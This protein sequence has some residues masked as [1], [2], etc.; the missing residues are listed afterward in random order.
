MAYLKITSFCALIVFQIFKTFSLQ[1]Q[2]Q[3]TVPQYQIGQLILEWNFSSS[4][5]YL[6]AIRENL[7]NRCPVSH[8][9]HFILRLTFFTFTTF[10][11]KCYKM[12]WVIAMYYKLKRQ[13]QI[14]SHGSPVVYSKSKICLHLSCSLQ[15]PVC[16]YIRQMLFFIFFFYGIYAP[17]HRMHNNGATVVSP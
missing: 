12:W 16:S 6:A 17:M 8:C 5:V 3:Y 7:T 9:L 10:P 13:R 4:Y 15:L 2:K 11:S 1:P 14:H